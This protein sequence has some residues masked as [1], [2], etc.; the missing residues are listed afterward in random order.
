MKVLV[1]GA[2]VVGVTAAYYL[3]RAGHEVQV[4]ERREGPGLE[5]SYANG[6]Q[7]LGE[8]SHGAAQFRPR[9]RA[10]PD[11]LFTSSGA[12]VLGRT[13]L[14]QLHSPARGAHHCRS[15]PPRSL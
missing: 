4:L 3:V 9:R 13:V 2:G 15:S 14:T 8:T 6:G 1:L 10:L 11:P 5:A 12:L 7:L